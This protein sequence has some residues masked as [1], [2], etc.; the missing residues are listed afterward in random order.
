MAMLVCQVIGHGE[1]NDS[2][3]LWSGDSIEASEAVEL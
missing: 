3:V 2:L 1:L